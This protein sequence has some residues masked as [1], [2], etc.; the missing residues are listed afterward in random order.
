MGKEITFK[1]EKIGDVGKTAVYAYS[2]YKEE[3]ALPQKGS[4]SAFELVET[5]AKKQFQ[6]ILESSVSPYIVSITGYEPE[7][8]LEEGQ[9]VSWVIPRINEIS[10]RYFQDSKSL[11]VRSSDLSKNQNTF[12]KGIESLVRENPS[13]DEVKDFFK[14]TSSDYEKPLW[15]QVLAYSLRSGLELP[16]LGEDTHTDSKL[17]VRKLGVVDTLWGMSNEHIPFAQKRWDLYKFIRTVTFEEIQNLSVCDNQTKIMNRLKRHYEH[18]TDKELRRVY[19]TACQFE[20]N[21]RDMLTQIF[22]NE[23]AIGNEVAYALGTKS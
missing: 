15:K 18:S 5:H 7:N 8:L 2:S 23:Q 22:K 11:F 6:S 4:E 10:R 16:W 3:L 14:N 17:I 21:P 20:A 12:S 19:Q 1:A 13:D 9:M